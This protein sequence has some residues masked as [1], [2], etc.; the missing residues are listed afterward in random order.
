MRPDRPYRGVK[1]KSNVADGESCDRA[2]FLVA[3]TTFELQMDDFALI[4]RQRLNR[5]EHPREGLARVMPGLKIGCD[6]D[7]GVVEWSQTPG[8]FP[9][10][11]REIAADR[12][13]PGRDASVEPLAVFPAQPEE[14]LL[15]NIAGGVQ[16]TEQP[17]CVTKQRLLILSQRV[18]YPL[19]CRPHA[20]PNEDNGAARIFLE[21]KV[22]DPLVSNVCKVSPNL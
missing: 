2:D 11:E 20:V 17:L 21:G 1:K 22:R 14:R 9:G 8:L 16:I 3:Q 4:A 19:R 15:D 12:E 13:E 10:V 5:R 6:L 18:D 7:V